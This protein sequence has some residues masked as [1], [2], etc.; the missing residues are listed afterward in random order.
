MHVIRACSLR[1]EGAADPAELL[2]WT[3]QAYQAERNHLTAFNLGMAHYRNGEFELARKH[4]E[5]AL[6]LTNWFIYYPALAMTHHRLG[7]AEAAREWLDKAEWAFGHFKGTGERVK[8]LDQHP[9]WQD[10]AHFE[11][12]L[13]EARALI[14]GDKKT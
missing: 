5:E 3:R 10:W 14:E 12:M 4:I 2:R 13:L 7:Q 9:Y 1:A 8:Y 6:T 11:V